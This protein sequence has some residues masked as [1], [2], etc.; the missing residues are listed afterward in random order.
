MVDP[1]QARFLA[2]YASQNFVTQHVASDPPYQV[3]TARFVNTRFS[4]VDAHALAW[5][6][7]KGTTASDASSIHENL[8]RREC[9]YGHS[10]SGSS[11]HP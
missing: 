9:V 2:P 4:H 3:L 6:N 11:I 5:L 8:L 10:R 1:E 7:R